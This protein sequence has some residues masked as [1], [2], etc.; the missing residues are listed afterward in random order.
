M[1]QLVTLQDHIA[2]PPSSVA[3][4]VAI[5]RAVNARYAN[6]VIPDVG[7]CIAHANTLEATTGIVLPSDPNV[8]STVSFQIAVFRPI[9]SE[10]IVGRIRAC[11]E[12]K[13][14]F[15]TMD[16]FDDIIIPPEH[17]PENSFW[18]ANAQLWC[19]RYNQQDLE[20][21]AFEL[22]FLIGAKC[23]FRVINE[24]FRNDAHQAKLDSIRRRT[25]SMSAN[26]TEE[27]IQSNPASAVRQ[28]TVDVSAY[29]ITGSMAADGLGLVD[30]WKDTED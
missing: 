30:W 5:R 18:D 22:P 8:H 29:L 7:L 1:F 26:T 10:V 16:F 24:S 21:T 3:K 2:L 20:N 28:E 19:W 4:H 12:T 17:L 11:H 23:R 25:T 15:V 9:M 6:R 13:G 14:I 27:A